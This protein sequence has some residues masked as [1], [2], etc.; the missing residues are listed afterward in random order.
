MIGVI[1][2]YNLGKQI[3]MGTFPLKRFLKGQVIENR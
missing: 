1:F 2:L 3:S